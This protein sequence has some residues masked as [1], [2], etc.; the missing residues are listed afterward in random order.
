MPP[1]APTAVGSAIL[2]GISTVVFAS[3]GSLVLAVIALAIGGVA[4]IASESTEM[5]IVQLQAPDAERGRVIGAYTMFG[6]GMMT[7]GGVTAGFLGSLLGIQAA[8]LA[9]GLVLTVGSAVVGAWLLLPR[10]R[11]S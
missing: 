4:K 9:S 1:T 6:P 11:R 8:V 7:F 3:S 5:S 2:L 10:A